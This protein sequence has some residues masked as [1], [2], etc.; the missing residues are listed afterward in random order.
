M[1]QFF[2]E[3]EVVPEITALSDCRHRLPGDF[4][5]GVLPEP[6]NQKSALE[7]IFGTR[8]KIFQSSA[9]LIKD[10]TS[11]HANLYQVISWAQANFDAKK[12]E[13]L[14]QEQI[15]TLAKAVATVVKS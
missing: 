4:R 1:K 12:I 13:A 11:V 6:P 15:K 7:E 2:D 10:V 5:I 14:G 9:R 8:F 3:F